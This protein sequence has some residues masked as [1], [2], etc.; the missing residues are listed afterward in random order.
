MVLQTLMRTTSTNALF[1]VFAENVIGSSPQIITQLLLES[2]LLPLFKNLG[3][4]NVFKVTIFSK[5][6]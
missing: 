6:T 4:N 2:T 1:I 3:D 5:K